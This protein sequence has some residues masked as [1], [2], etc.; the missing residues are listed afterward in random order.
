MAKSGDLGLNRRSG[1]H[2]CSWPQASERF[3]FEPQV[4]MAEGWLALD[5]EQDDGHD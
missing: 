1:P 2:P 3:S 4:E 5:R